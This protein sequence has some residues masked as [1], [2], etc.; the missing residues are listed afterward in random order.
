MRSMKNR[1]RPL[2]F[3]LAL[4]LLFGAFLSNPS[5]SLSSG[6]A[7]NE[8]TAEAGVTYEDVLAGLADPYDFF[9]PLDE[10]S[11]P[12][13][14]GYEKAIENLHVERMYNTKTQ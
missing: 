7:E 11:V 2:S 10:S 9:G 6:P 1:T 13:A 4:C 14:V 8:Q 3:L 12:E 5:I